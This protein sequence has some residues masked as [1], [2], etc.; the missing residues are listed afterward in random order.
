M[1]GGR[2]RCEQPGA[3]AAGDRTGS[4]AL[5]ATAQTHAAA[6][7]QGLASGKGTA[8]PGDSNSTTENQDGDEGNGVSV[9]QKR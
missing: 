4:R 7:D 3:P 5:W 8:V 1:A 6:A 9:Y 2:S